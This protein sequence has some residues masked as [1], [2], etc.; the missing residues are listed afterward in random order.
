MRDYS[1]QAL[2]PFEDRGARLI[3][4]APQPQPRAVLLALAWLGALGSAANGCGFSSPAAAACGSNGT[5][6]YLRHTT[7]SQRSAARSP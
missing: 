5:E 7:C 2:R 4:N 6:D 3:S 1:F